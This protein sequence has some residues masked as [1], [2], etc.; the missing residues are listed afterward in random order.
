MKYERN[1]YSDFWASFRNAESHTLSL[2]IND[3]RK[4]AAE[5]ILI[6]HGYKSSLLGCKVTPSRAAMKCFEGLTDADATSLMRCAQIKAMDIAR[7][8]NDSVT[9]KKLEDAI[10]SGASTSLNVSS[11]LGVD[12]LAD[13]IDGTS[14]WFHQKVFICYLA[15]KKLFLPDR[16]HQSKEKRWNRQRTYQHE[17]LITYYQCGVR[18]TC[19]L[20]EKDWATG[21]KDTV[22]EYFIDAYNREI[23]ELDFTKVDFSCFKDLFGEDFHRVIDSAKS[24]LLAE[25]MDKLNTAIASLRS[26]NADLE[27]EKVLYLKLREPVRR[28]IRTNDEEFY[29]AVWDNTSWKLHWADMAVGTFLRK[30]LG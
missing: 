21:C 2:G 10:I 19:L 4:F 15:A 5:A 3:V 23:K 17:E 18:H 26:V 22:L 16:S 12:T 30:I 20:S 27:K 9:L 1:Q 11:S 14:L 29:I 24:I 6:L 28:W 25:E 7:E 13:Y 8:K